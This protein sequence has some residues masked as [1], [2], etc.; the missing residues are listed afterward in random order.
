MLTVAKITGGAATGYAHYLE[1]KTQASELGDYYLKGGE[2]VEAPGR[3]V[4]GAERFGL[5]PSQRVTGEQL[6]T[7]MAVQRPDTGEQLRRIGGSG[8]AVAAIDA[9]FSAPKSVSAA[10]AIAGPVLRQRIE[11]AHEEAIDR[12]LGYATGQVPMLRR[13]LGPDTV[14]HEKAVGVV[15]TSWRHTTARA[16]ADQVPDPQLHSHVLLHAAI[17]RDGRLVAID[18]RS[19]LT[20]QREVGAAY[21]T[22][23]A[24][25]L[26]QLGFQINRGTGRGGRY[27]EIDGIPQSLLDRW[28]SRRHQVQEAIRG[29][30]EHQEQILEARIAAGGPG[31]DTAFEELELLRRYGQLAPKEER[32]AALIARSTKTP[33]RVE[34]LD[35]QW[36]RDALSHEVSRERLEVLR[37]S[38]KPPLQS[39]SPQD[40]LTALTEF[41]STFAARDAR[42]A[43]LEQSAGAPIAVALEQLQALR[44]SGEILLLEDGTG[45]T[46]DHRGYEQAV[47]TITQRLAATELEPI[48]EHLSARE[49][50][51]LDQELAANGGR[52]SDEQRTAVSLACGEH[53]LVVIE[54]HAGTGKSTTLTGV[55]R[56]HQN[57]GRQVI[58]TS[59]AALAAERLA[60]D[61][62][63]HGVECYAYSTAGLHAAITS[64][65]V[66]LGPETTVIHDEAAL[67][68][69][70]EQLRLLHA[71]EISG[72]RLIAVGDPRQ[73]QPVGA[74]G[75]WDHI[76]HTAREAGALVELTVNQRAKDPADQEAQALFRD[77]EIEPA[78]RLY[79]DRGHVRLDDDQRQVEDQALD[80]AHHDRTA[81]RSTLVIAQTSN[82]HLDELNARA[83]AIRH[84]AGQLGQDGLEIPGRPYKLHAGDHIQVRHTI[85]HP[86]HGPLRNGTGATVTGIDPERRE[87]EL[88]LRDG[89]RLTLERDQIEQ[90]DLRLAY[91]Q[92]PFPAQG[93]TTDT[94]H[95]IVGTQATREGTYVAI[96]RARERTEVY[97]SVAGTPAEQDPLEQL[98]DRVSQTEPEVPSI[99]TPL[100]HEN[101]ITTSTEGGAGGHGEH[102]LQAED[103]P[104][105]RPAPE[106]EQQAHHELPDGPAATGD[107]ETVGIPETALEPD[108]D[109]QP[110]PVMPEAARRLQTMPART[111]PARDAPASP[112]RQLE[113]EQDEPTRSRSRGWEL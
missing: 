27:F 79:H 83:Q 64:G 58:V 21:R 57:A 86:G 8:E 70:R 89:T 91:V 108:T 112:D 107:D 99:N 44:A 81:G 23:L 42:A 37:V 22:E 61:L 26:H 49:A 68:S 59:T 28:S 110:H 85:R 12:A 65:R 2:R 45:T 20:H 11:L 101:T 88:Q 87:L 24:R 46:R 17:R 75:L 15:A 62:Q 47:V 106:R 7:L 32:W 5:D 1:S 4:Q 96:T 36:R 10:W 30:L 56:A 98:V 73:N 74:G 94:A 43:A 31:A 19:W 102:M 84:Q 33:L 51:R 104:P 69:T 80:A 92:H 13:R 55:A 48:P 41:D 18:S 50:D 6:R 78:I 93:H 97:H 63:E 72:A 113:P 52:L 14:V 16:V 76:Q 77:G 100:A 34:D 3:W 103:D 90:A 53:R 109:L 25:E 39:A 29:R 40:V 105:L 67:A 9:T 38:P 111:W 60:T 66:A 35:N 82:E 71:V 54:G 95:I